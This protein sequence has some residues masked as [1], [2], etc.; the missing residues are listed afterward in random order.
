MEEYAGSGA[1]FNNVTGYWVLEK[2][3]L[4]NYDNILFY[5][6]FVDIPGLSAPD[7]WVEDLSAMGNIEEFSFE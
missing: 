1:H 4:D 6:L 2:E 7:R 5:E 3:Y